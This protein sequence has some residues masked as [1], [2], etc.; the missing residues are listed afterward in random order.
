MHTKDYHR[1]LKDDTDRIIF[2]TA[3]EKILERQRIKENK[4][5]YEELEEKIQLLEKENIR[6]KR[7]SHELV[8]I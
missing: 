6:L 7:L 4:P 2:E 5:S 3:N 8:R 1:H